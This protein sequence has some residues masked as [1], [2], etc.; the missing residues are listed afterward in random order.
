VDRIAFHP[1]GKLLASANVDG[2]VGLWD[3]EKGTN[4]RTLG[5]DPKFDVD[6]APDLSKTIEDM[7]PNVAVDHLR[8][9]A[10]SSYKSEVQFSSNGRL[11][12]STDRGGTVKLWRLLSKDE[13]EEYGWSRRH[14]AHDLFS[15]PDGTV[16]EEYQVLACNQIGR[17]PL[18]FSPD[19]R[20]LASGSGS[21][22]EGRIWEI[23][24]RQGEIEIPDSKDAKDL[25]FSPDGRLLAFDQYGRLS[26]REAGSGL[27]VWGRELFGY[28]LSS[29]A[30]VLD[31]RTLATS[32]SPDGMQF[33]DA[34]TGRLVRTWRRPPRSVRNVKVSPNGRQFASLN[35]DTTVTLWDCA[36]L[37]PRSTFR[38]RTLPSYDELDFSRDGS[39]IRVG[40]MIPPSSVGPGI[41]LDEFWNASDGRPLAIR[42]KCRDTG[43]ILSPGGTVL[44][45]IF[46]GGSH[47]WELSTGRHRDGPLDI[48]RFRNLALTRDGRRLATAGNISVWIFE[49]S[50]W[51]ETGH[52]EVELSDPHELAF[53]PDGLKIAVGGDPR[54]D[55]TVL[56]CT[57]PS[58]ASRVE[59]EAAGVI[60]RTV[61]RF[62]RSSVWHPEENVLAMML[63]K[64]TRDPALSQPVKDEATRLFNVYSK[65]VRERYLAF[66]L[67]AFLST[68]VNREWALA[69]IDGSEF[70]TAEDRRIAR[71]LIESYPPPSIEQLQNLAAWSTVKSPKSDA[72]SNQRALSEIEEACRT[73]WDMESLITLGA[74]RYRVGQDAKAVETLEA[75]LA[76]SRS[77]TG[78]EPRLYAFLAMAELKRGHRERAEIALKQMRA[79]VK[80]RGEIAPDEDTQACIQ[81]AEASI[82]D[83]DFPANPFAPPRP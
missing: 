27:E 22:P 31:G 12:A 3:V 76:E 43:F 25:A 2:T 1:D 26:V 34:A 83:L 33:W 7:G 67:D 45:T 20:L 23:S 15:L 29:L 19:D 10:R 38:L 73:A 65:N 21:D 69:I 36:T 74:A 49:T 30:F 28:N 57:P 77:R 55:V 42:P 66:L 78:Y 44:F 82:L 16:V 32:T 17:H 24:R 79:F 53:S 11:L 63:E 51:R 48:L 5:P 75:A 71:T 8:Y 80:R 50:A 35:S 70:A 37:E 68:E 47:S 54:A 56:D 58:P 59:R 61:P 46:R 60:E 13:E 40:G 4:V 62:S 72:K 64:I 14:H 39:L 41:P 81:E 6:S 52:M 18:A 9:E